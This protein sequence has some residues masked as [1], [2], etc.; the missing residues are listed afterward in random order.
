MKKEQEIGGLFFRQRIPEVGGNHPT[1]L[2]LHGFT[3]DE[4]SMWV[5]SAKIPDNAYIIAPRAIYQSPKGGY[6]WVEVRRKIWPWIDEFQPGIESLLELLTSRNFPDADL[7]SIV[8]LGFS[9]GAALAYAMALL[10]PAKIRTI[11]GLA[12]FMPDG[13]EAISRNQPLSGKHV[14]VAH[15]NQDKTIP[16][17][18]AHEAVKILELAGASVS[19]CEDH[20]GH[21]LSAGCYKGLGSFLA[22]SLSG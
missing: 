21:K 7:S 2:M 8:V 14:F 6:Q 15:G 11:A 22:G 19:F 9:Q 20:V 10:H 12:S 3:G 17:Q 1:I 13:S 5:F 18:K 4:N 16:I